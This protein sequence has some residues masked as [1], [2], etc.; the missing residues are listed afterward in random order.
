MGDVRRIVDDL[1]PPTLD[2][3]GLLAALTAFADRLSIRDDTLKV[4]VEAADPLPELPPVV[5]V[6]AYLIATEAMTNVARH[7]RARRCLLRLPV[8]GDLT[9]EV[10]DDGIG[11]P[12]TAPLASDCP[13]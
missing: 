4:E 9:I 13:P 2:E 7:A 1:R 11:I 6:A 12:P 3:L 10:T 5:E 8:S